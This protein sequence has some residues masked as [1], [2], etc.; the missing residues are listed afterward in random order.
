MNE[1]LN[2]LEKKFVYALE[3]LQL[4]SV[5]CLGVTLLSFLIDDMKYSYLTWTLLGEGIVFGAVLPFFIEHIVLSRPRPDYVINEQRIATLA[6]L[7]MPD[8]VMLAIKKMDG[9]AGNR[10]DLSDK[11]L[12]RIGAARGAE[13][14]DTLCKYLS[15]ASKAP[16]DARETASSASKATIVPPGTPPENVG[17]A[18]QEL[19]RPAATL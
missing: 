1:G 2:V 14:L 3:L 18:M 12:G 10:D 5:V 16:S 8:D 4:T 11:F 7:K 13:F 19:A 6:A 15:T 17:P 9:F